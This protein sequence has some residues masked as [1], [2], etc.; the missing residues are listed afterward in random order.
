[1]TADYIQE[2]SNELVRRAKQKLER[3]IR[4]AVWRC[5]DNLLFLSSMLAEHVQACDEHLVN[6]LHI[7]LRQ[8]LMLQPEQGNDD[9]H[10]LQEWAKYVDDQWPSNSDD[11]TKATIENK[12]LLGNYDWL[13]Q[14]VRTRNA[15]VAIQQWKE[16]RILNI[17]V[18]SNKP[19]KRLLRSLMVSI[20][21]TGRK[22]Y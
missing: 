1:M 9:K 5:D 19:F 6:W 17:H 8:V 13:S 21:T 20:G 18:G 12:V 11:Q 4:E 14:Y 7:Q 10:V 2:L 16:E 3:H 15:Q 22:L